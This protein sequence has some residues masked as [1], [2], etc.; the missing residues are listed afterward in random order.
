[1]SVKD[2]CSENLSTNIRD[3]L[4]NLVLSENLSH[5]GMAKLQHTQLDAYRNWLNAGFQGDMD[6]LTHHLPIKEDPQLQFPGC[7]SALVFAA[8]YIAHHAPQG[9]HLATLPIAKY[10]Q[11]EDYHFWFKSKLDKIAQRLHEKYPEH[12]FIAQTDSGPLMERDLGARSG[13]G[14]QGKNTCLIHPKHGSYFF[15]GEILT[16]LDADTDKPTEVPMHCGTCTRCID[17]CPTQALDQERNLN[18]KKCI[19][20]W[21]IEA[22]G[23]APVEIRDQVGQYFFGCDI[24]QDVCPWNG[25]I[26]KNLPKSKFGPDAIDELRSILRSSNKALMRRFQNSPLSRARGSGLKRNAMMVIAHYRA[27]ELKA[28]VEEY[29]THETLGELAQWTLKQLQLAK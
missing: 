27:I 15:L 9:S 25:K 21:T 8:S 7:Q 22:K 12:L 13:L 10:A 29:T 11:I 6:Y 4:D 2:N 16:S 18:A 23:I 3:F 5:W 20:Y 1:M 17:A 26:F 14:W 28:E 19:S 24:C